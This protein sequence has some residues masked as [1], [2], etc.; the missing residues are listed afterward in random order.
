[1]RVGTTM[2]IVFTRL[3]HDDNTVACREIAPRLVLP[4]KD[5]NKEI[6]IWF[7]SRII[8]V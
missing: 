4:N 2:R 6:D 8:F 3:I 1:M 5:G 7:S